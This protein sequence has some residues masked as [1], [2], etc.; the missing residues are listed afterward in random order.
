MPDGMGCSVN[1]PKPVTDARALVD[2]S[3]RILLTS[4]RKPDG[5]ALGCMAALD[6]ALRRQGKDVQLLLLSPIP[7]WYAFLFDRLPPILGEGMTVD[8]LTAGG[9]DLVVIVDTNSRNQL[10]DLAG[11][12][13]KAHV[14]VLVI[15]HHATSDHLGRVEI[16]DTTAAAAGV[17]VHELIQSAGWSVTPD[18]ATAL[19]VAVATDTGWFRF[20]NTDVRVL[21]IAAQL[22]DAGADPAAVYARLYQNF[23]S[24]RFALMT[25][26]L[27]HMSLH[28][29]GRYAAQYLTAE[30]FRRTGAA[31]SDTE[32]LISECQRIGSVQVA[33]IF[34][35]QQDGRIRCSLRSNGAVNVRG[36]AEQFGGGGHT[37][38]AGTFLPAPVDHAMSLIQDQIASRLPDVP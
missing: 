8:Q 17:L 6:A 35:E 16:T 15:D 21:R 3:T 32:D 18:M 11:W 22:I 27:D 38:A 7:S 10:K 33:A 14:P 36:I 13:D 25:T 19:F 23:T 12:L 1:K 24:E 28:F 9:Y 20:S 4:H 31:Y 30:D 5:D 2:S 34:V 26:M 37:N 29:D